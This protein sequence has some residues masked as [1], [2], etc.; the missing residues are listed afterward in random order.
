MESSIGKLTDKQVRF[1]ENNQSSEVWKNVLIDL[2]DQSNTK[3]RW[4]GVSNQIEFK[5]IS[6]HKEVHT[7]KLP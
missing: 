1:I 5:N 6:F 3:E 2:G 7:R 4:S